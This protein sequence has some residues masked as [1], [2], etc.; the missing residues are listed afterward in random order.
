MAAERGIAAAFAQGHASEHRFNPKKDVSMVR[1]ARTFALSHTLSRRALI[2]GTAAAATLGVLPG[3]AP[4]QEARAGTTRVLSIADLHSAYGRL[5]QLLSL[6]RARARAAEAE[7]VL[8][9]INGDLF[10]LA[11]PVATRSRGAADLAFLSALNGI[12]PVI[13]NIGNHEPDFVDDMAE[14]IAL[15]EGAG[16]TAI[17]NIVDPR[18]GRL[19][20]PVLTRARIAGADT[21]VA[22]IATDN[23]FTYPEAIRPQLAVPAPV[24]YAEALIGRLSGGPM[25]LLTHAGVVADKAILPLLPEGSIAVGGHDHLTLTDEGARTY[26]HGGAWGRLLTQI[27]VTAGAAGLDV[28]VMQADVTTDAPGDTALADLIAALEAEHLTTEDLAPVGISARAMDLK[29]AILF[30]TE[31]VRAATGADIAVLGHTTFGTGLPQGPVRKYDFDAYIRFDGDI[32]TAEVD[33]TTLR[34]ILEMANQDEAT[35]LDARTGDYVHAADIEID[36]AATYVLATNGWTAMNQ[37]RYLGTDTLEFVPVAGL[38]LK[39]T[40]IGALG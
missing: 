16:A 17:S 24:D 1:P 22:G 21:V 3:S 28:T 39:S 5:P 33:G 19:Y 9:V 18:T 4:A 38:A 35:S 27:D 14:A 32:Q 30:A 13:V 10:E 2:A 6:M 40:V 23:L 20:A 15:I 26:V 36:D 29:E 25:L 7:D 8:I 34:V 31:A 37:V 11:N 12:A